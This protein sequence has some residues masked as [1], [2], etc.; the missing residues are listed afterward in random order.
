MIQIAEMLPP[1]QSPLWRL[2]KQAG[3]DYAVGGLA[4][5]FG[6]PA[7]QAIVPNV[8]PHEHLLNA[9]ALSGITRHGSRIVGPLLGGALLTTIGAGYLGDRFAGKSGLMLALF[10]PF[11]FLALGLAIEGE[12]ELDAFIQWSDQ[13]PGQSLIEEQAGAP[14]T[15]A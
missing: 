6:T 14:P 10:L 9:I 13:R 1:R 3:I 15:A 7:E 11:H 4:R 8:V 5:A 12:A 2:C